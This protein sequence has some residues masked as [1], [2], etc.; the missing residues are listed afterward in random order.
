MHINRRSCIVTSLLIALSCIRAFA[1]DA[2]PGQRIFYT[3][4]SFHMFVPGMIE[5]MVKTMDIQHQCGA[6]CDFAKDRMGDGVELS[7]SGSEMK[8]RLSSEA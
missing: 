2:V 1:A 6:A 5:E 7:A 3:G 4:H 8:R